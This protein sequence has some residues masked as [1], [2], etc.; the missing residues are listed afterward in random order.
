[1]LD[2]R[3]RG[4]FD[5]SCVPTAVIT[6]GNFFRSDDGVGPFIAR[7]GNPPQPGFFIID[8]REHPEAI[9]DHVI[10]IQPRRIIF[11]D[12]ADFSGTPGDCRW[13]AVDAVP[14]HTLTTHIFPLPAIAAILNHDT[15]AEVIFLGIQVMDVRYGESLSVPVEQTGMEFIALLTQDR[16]ALKSIRHRSPTRP[17]AQSPSE[18]VDPVLPLR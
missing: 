14:Q 9:I 5:G 3:I 13:I 6:V 4:L 16:I 18:S 2:E 1:M 11:I 8:A 7:N 17:F 15:N 10:A 12:A